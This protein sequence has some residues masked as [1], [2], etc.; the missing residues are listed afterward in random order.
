MI[1]KKIKEN[2]GNT[3]KKDTAKTWR[4]RYSLK[5]LI[6]ILTVVMLLL[7]LKRTGNFES[8]PRAKMGIL[9]VTQLEFE[10]DV[11][12]LDGQWEFYW[13]QFLNPNEVT[14]NP[15]TE[16]VSLP[17]SWNK[18]TFNENTYSGDGYAT[19][20]LTFITKTNKRL[21][22][23]I[24]RLRTAY[25]LWVNGE[26]IA[27]AGEI[28]KSKDTMKPQYLP[29]VSFFEAKKGENEILIQVSNFY[30]RSGGMLESIKLG[31]EEK[32]LE[33]KLKNIAMEFILFGSLICIGAYHL[34]LFFF[35]RKKDSSSMYFGLFCVLMGIRIMLGGECF[36]YYLFPEF[37]WEI[38]HKILTLTYYLGVPLVL[39]FFMSVFPEYFHK[40]IIKAAQIMGSIFTGI[41]LLTPVRIFTVV[42]IVY[43]IWSIGVILYIA[44]IFIKICIHKEKD[45]WLIGLGAMVLLMSS[46]ND[47]IFFSP[48]M[49]DN[50]FLFLRAL[51]RVGN[52]TPLGQLIFAC[53]N[54]LLIAKRFSDALEHE[55][56]MTAKLTEMN[57]HLDEL[58]L[59]RTK[60]LAESNQ[61]IEY[62]NLELERK[63]HILKK[64]SFKDPLTGVW[65]RRKYDQMLEKEWNRCLR[66]QKPIALL[67]LDIDDFKRFNDFYG[68]MEGDSCLIKVGQTLKDAL[69]CSTNILARYG[70]EEFIVLLGGAGKEEAIMTAELMRKKIE[71]LAIPHEKSPISNYVTVSIG[72]TFTVPDFGSSYQ[73]LFN[74]VDKALYQAKDSGKNQVR[75]LQKE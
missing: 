19:Y 31:S 69:A 56:V 43:Q 55:E 73:E 65:N 46:I 51:F 74:T 71:D 24:P 41:V 58:V 13:N 34:T 4:F 57:T 20:R 75:F 49:H 1:F 23:K 60:E 42:N 16:Y 5:Y 59:Q 63:N 12:S 67:L 21:A 54:S 3:I 62:Q 25:K 10:T 18:Y 50:Q 64:F 66:E 35:R 36:F 37:S 68:H 29:Q 6:I 8:H 15:V 2:N 72:C 17:S 9:D 38:A 47:I 7:F 61:K 27:S 32:I 52:L 22:L 33:L 70:G 26:L 45:S 11:V 28:G 48:W 53:T 39:L 40:K 14:S 44:I 30:H